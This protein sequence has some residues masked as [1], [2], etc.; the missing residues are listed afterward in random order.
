MVPPHLKCQPIHITTS[1]RAWVYNA[2]VGDTMCSAQVVYIW[3]EATFFFL[4]R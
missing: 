1:K 4:V 2:D 3:Y